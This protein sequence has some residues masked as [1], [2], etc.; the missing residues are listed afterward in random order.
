MAKILFV[1]DD[2]LTLEMLS[3]AVGLHGHTA[4]T[5]NTAEK[6]LALGASE[7]PDLILLDMNMPGTNG[8]AIIRQLRA[9]PETSLIPVLMLSASPEIDMESQVRAAGGQGYLLKPI[10]LK[11]LIEVIREYT[12]S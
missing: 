9:Q 1:D 12:P 3:K 7:Q 2:P 10:N 11:H 8:I 6:A 4:L 5:G